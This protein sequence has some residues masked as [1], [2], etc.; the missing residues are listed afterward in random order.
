MD[1]LSGYGSLMNFASDIK[2][3]TQINSIWEQGAE[4]NMWT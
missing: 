3:K 4:E 1:Y 2:G